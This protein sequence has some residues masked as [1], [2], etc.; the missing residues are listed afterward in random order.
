MSVVSSNVGAPSGMLRVT[1][2][3]LQETFEFLL[4]PMESIE[5]V[6]A[7]L[8]S[9]LPRIS[10]STSKMRLIYMGKVLEDQQLLGSV[11]TEDST[12]HCVISQTYQFDE[13][14]SLLPYESD[15]LNFGQD[16]ERGVWPQELSDS[17]GENN[18][19]SEAPGQMNQRRDHQLFAFGVCLGFLLVGI[20]IKLTSPRL[21]R[22]T[23]RGIVCGVFLRLLYFL[24]EKAFAFEEMQQETTLFGE[25]ARMFQQVRLEH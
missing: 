11:L 12:I 18:V 19:V 22:A 3:T 15:S 10:P 5:Q 23:S 16:L 21:N 25:E 8:Y 24:H 9:Q 1:I 7:K 20:F 6:K 17:E 13:D 4:S 2:V 14:D